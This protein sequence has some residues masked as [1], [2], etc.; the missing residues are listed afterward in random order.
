MSS[1]G[2]VS[3]SR[4]LEYAQQQGAQMFDLRFSDLHGLWHHISYPI[5]K[6]NAGL[7]SRWIR[8]RRLLDSRVGRHS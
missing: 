8:D 2:E 3:A 6:V 5:V 4:V 1:H 7:V